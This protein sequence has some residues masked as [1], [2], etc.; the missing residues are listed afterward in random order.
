MM[1][2]RAATAENFK[3]WR[4]EMGGISIEKAAAIL[5]KKVGTTYAYQSGER[6]ITKS[7]MI[8][9]SMLAER[10]RVTN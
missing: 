3:R 4:E 6:R 10:E 1:R 2:K 5:G 8:L 9:M 7:T